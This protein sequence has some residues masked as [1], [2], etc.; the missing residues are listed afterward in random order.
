MTESPARLPNA[1]ISARAGWLIGLFLALVLAIVLGRSFHH[2]AKATASA[3]AAGSGTAS[4]ERV[5]LAA[6]GRIEG[7]TEVVDI[8]AGVDG[9][10]ADIPVKEGQWVESGT[11]VAQIDRPDLQAEVRAANDALESARQ[12]RIRIVRGSRD[13][14]RREAEAKRVAAE[15]SLLQAQ[16]QYTR[17]DALYKEGIVSHDLWEQ[18]KRDFDLAAANLRAAQESEKLAKAGP[19]PEEVARAD[20][21]VQKAEAAAKSASAQLDMCLVKARI[22]GTV[23]RI[24]MKPGESF[25]SQFPRPILSMADTS[26]LRVRV[27]VDERDIG[28]VFLGQP[29]LV[30]VDAYPGQHLTGT[31]ARIEPLMGRKKVRTGDPAEKSDR[32]VLETL[33]NLNKSDVPLALGLRVTVQFLGKPQTSRE[34]VEPSG[35]R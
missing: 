6:P 18:Y 7:L 30:V 32:D 10:V 14:E 24:Y 34:S 17:N 31:V 19:L 27:E 22:S 4:P 35:A 26:A 15:A 13:E 16:Q 2:E 12:S 3:P 20:A 29:A 25:S 8:G 21:E 1:R 9:V 5:V 33:V 23:L 28:R 11:V